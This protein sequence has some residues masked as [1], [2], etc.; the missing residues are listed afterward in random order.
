MADIT[1]KKRSRIVTLAKH[2][3]YTQRNIA[4][5]VGVSQKSVSRIIKQQ[6]ETGS[7]IPKRKGKSELGTR[8]FKSSDDIGADTLLKKYRRYR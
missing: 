3:G 4:S 7:V 8:Y 5:I 6:A 2:T 1:P